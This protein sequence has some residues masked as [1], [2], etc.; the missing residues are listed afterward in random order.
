MDQ[1]KLLLAA[2]DELQFTNKHIKPVEDYPFKL[3]NLLLNLRAEVEEYVNEND[4]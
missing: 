2:I 4:S 3:T 1:I